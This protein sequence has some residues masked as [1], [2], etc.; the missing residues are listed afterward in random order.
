[1]ATVSSRGVTKNTGSNPVLT[2]I[3]KN[4]KIL[5]YILAI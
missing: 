4:G 5:K 1:M 3:K 2:T